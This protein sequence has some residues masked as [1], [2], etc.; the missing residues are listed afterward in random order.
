[1][2]RATD[3]LH[4]LEGRLPLGFEELQRL[5]ETTVQIVESELVDGRPVELFTFGVLRREAGVTTFTPHS[6]LHA[7]TQ[8]SGD[9]T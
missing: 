3:I 9:D 8:D 2:A 5:Y 7:G 6:S 1:M 4:R